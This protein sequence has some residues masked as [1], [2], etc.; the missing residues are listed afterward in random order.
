MWVYL[1][2]IC[3]VDRIYIDSFI[4][5]AIDDA[6]HAQLRGKIP[7]FVNIYVLS[8]TEKP[9]PIRTNLGCN[10]VCRLMPTLGAL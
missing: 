9:E 2:Y 3:K 6:A 7:G 8:I 10:Q 1:Q 5:P 4:D